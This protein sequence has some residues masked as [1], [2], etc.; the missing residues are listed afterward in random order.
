MRFFLIY[1][2]YISWHYTKGLK[3]LLEIWQN[4]L[5][6]IIN[7][8]SIGTLLTTLF[9]P[10]ERLQ[11]HY[12]GGLDLGNFFSVLVVNLIMRLVGFFS[13]IILIILGITIFIATII[14]GVISFFIWLI[15]P[16]LM[17]FILL[18][19]LRSL[20]NFPI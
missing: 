19:V 18:A 20:F 10:F 16:I 12:R 11:E 7:F 15:L 4:F 14:L 1:P 6:F 8:F 5:W 2:Y 17:M 9:S 13:R 3:N